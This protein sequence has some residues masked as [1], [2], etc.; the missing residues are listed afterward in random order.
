[1]FR[2]PNTDLAPFAL[3]EFCKSM[4]THGDGPHEPL[5]TSLSKF[6]GP[7]E[8]CEVRRR[9]LYKICKKV[10]FPRARAPRGRDAWG[11]LVRIK[12]DSYD[13]PPS[14][15]S[16]LYKVLRPGWGVR[17]VAGPESG[18]IQKI[19]V[20]KPPLE[21]GVGALKVA[22]ESSDIAGISMI[23]GSCQTS[24]NHFDRAP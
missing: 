14:F 17:E 24:S 20:R 22:E 15:G 12:S 6:R 4:Q 3:C 2:I 23:T 7:P 9:V 8:W 11:A 10:Y 1:V 19:S 18:R 21:C 16:L 5:I 13:R